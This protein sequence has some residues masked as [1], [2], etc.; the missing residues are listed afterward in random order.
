MTK[1]KFKVP[2]EPFV[3]D[4]HT[5]K[6]LMIPEIGNSL[7]TQPLAV[8]LAGFLKIGNGSGNAHMA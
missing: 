8:H 3:S 2:T 4:H 5:A 1:R 6:A 7:Q